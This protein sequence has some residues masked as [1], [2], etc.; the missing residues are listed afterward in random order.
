MSRASSPRAARL[1]DWAALLQAVE[2]EHARPSRRPDL[3]AQRRYLDALQTALDG[4]DPT[5]LLAMLADRVPL[6]STVLLPVVGEVLFDLLQGRSNG[7]PSKLTLRDDITIRRAF[8][9][10]TA[11][12][13]AADAR[14]RSAEKYDVSDDTIKRSLKRTQ[15]AN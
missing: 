1:R 3:G 10:D 11:T 9:R 4:R 8:D 7:R 15:P 5:A 12:M 13:S 6:S 14:L 2:D